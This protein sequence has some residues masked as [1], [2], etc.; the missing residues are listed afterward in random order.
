MKI[1]Q[2]FWSKPL[3]NANRDVFQNRFNG[4]WINYR[5]CLL[6]IAYSCLTISRFYPK[7]ELYTDDYG[8]DLFY[9]KLRLPYAKFYTSLNN[10]DVDEALWAYGKVYTYSLQKE[11]F[12]HID[13]DIFIWGKFSDDLMQSDV[14]VQNIEKISAGITD[15]YI[16]IMQYIRHN[17]LSAPAI[18]RN[19]SVSYAL[20][21]GVFGGKD[22]DFIHRYAQTS[23]EV[24]KNTYNDIIASGRY[25][26][27]FNII[28]E[29]LLLT[30]MVRE[31]FVPIK[32]ILE[33]SDSVD[34]TRFFSIESAQFDSKFIHCLGAL[35]QSDV[36]C[37]QIEYRMKNEFP[38]YYERILSYL[39]SMGLA[40]PENDLSLQHYTEFESIYSKMKNVYSI[41][42]LLQN[43][44]VRLR[45][46]YK[47]V[48]EDDKAY[49]QMYDNKE[50]IKGWGKLL[51]YF[52]EP[53]TGEEV[54]Q[55]VYRS[56]IL[57]SFSLSQIK[58]AVFYLITNCIYI[59]RYL[60][61]V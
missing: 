54:V 1:I 14:V 43:Y 24:V 16:A 53:I 32:C 22:I 38:E 35:K 51:V 29:Q 57:P 8:F 34:I 39:T 58:N 61:V 3:I 17:V 36:I 9:N 56:C 55:Y 4:G 20:N 48:L 12:L 26:G 2:S 23:L 31:E 19:S 27:L 7:L 18:I 49:I 52:T 33:E 40:F 41:D 13:N 37:E 28:F 46:G 50:T 44:Q 6:S 45:D 25:K 59:T 60:T 15:D 5:Y 30:E 21:M 47:V 10:V 42:D 11:P